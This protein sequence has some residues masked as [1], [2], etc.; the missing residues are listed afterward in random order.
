MLIL[1][2]S[3]DLLDNLQSRSV[4][5]FY[6][7]I[8]ELLGCSRRVHVIFDMFYYNL[9][10]IISFI[11]ILNLNGTYKIYTLNRSLR[12]ITSFSFCSNLWL[13]PVKYAQ[14][15]RYIDTL[16]IC[17][18]YHR[19]LYVPFK[20]KIRI[21]EIIIYIHACIKMYLFCP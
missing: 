19:I 15:L 10:F 4:P 18:T 9:Q 17:N 1:K 2:T 21:K 16:I 6:K 3:K 14:S 13:S 8:Y 5:A 7:H 12:L 20:F 11:L